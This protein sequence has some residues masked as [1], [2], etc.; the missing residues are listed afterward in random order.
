MLAEAKAN[1]TTVTVRV[2]VPGAEVLVDGRPLGHSPLSGPVFL[3]PGP[4]RFEAQKKELGSAVQKVDASAGAA[5]EVDLKL[6]ASRTIHR[7]P[8]APRATAAPD[9]AGKQRTRQ[10]LI[11]TGSALSG[12]LALT[13]IA[14][15][16]GAAAAGA[17]LTKPDSPTATKTAVVVSPQGAVVTVTGRF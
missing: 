16:I 6:S 13:G 11:C 9:D 12:A 2:D 10:I 1:I 7:A 4:H 17:L 8:T 5:P 15:A 3:E 14:T